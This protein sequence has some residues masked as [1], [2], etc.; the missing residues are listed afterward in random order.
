MRILVT[1]GAGF[2]GSHLC[3]ALMARGHELWCVDNLHLGRLENI[4]HLRVNPKFH[5]ERIDVMER[6]AMNQL[7]QDGQ[8]EFVY[9]MAANSDIQRG[10]MDHQVDLQLTFLTTHEILEHMLVHGVKK[11]FF[12]STSAVFGETKDT[13]HENY[14]PLQPISFYGASKLAAESFL[15]VFVNNYGFK[16]FILRFPNIVGPRAT[17][18]AI[19]DFI[20][21]LK[22]NPEK[23][24]VFGDGTQRKPYLYVED[25]VEAILTVVEKADSPLSVY[26][27]GNEDLTK[28]SD[29]ARIV[30]EEMK[31]SNCAI[32]YTGGDRGW[33]G[34]VP[35]FRYDMSKI[36]K[37]GWK[38]T[39]TSNE[40]VRL[41]V[42][43][44][45]SKS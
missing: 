16:A 7:F 44:I 37:L 21:R 31:L 11:I 40:S 39:Y 27:A 14:G 20:A 35:Y 10:S 43:K 18:G 1:G 28:V 32:E 5:F 34:D 15:S 24:V 25:L 13:L 22:A 19:F 42:Q 6:K 12:A 41:A 30:L 29:M 8:F 23:L 36:K 4:A 9:H 17:H 45:L 3:D 2:I 38:P 26:H 33:T